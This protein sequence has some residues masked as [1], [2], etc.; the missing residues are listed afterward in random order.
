MNDKRTTILIAAMTLFSENG[1]H[2]TSMQEVADK[3]NVSK[4]TIY[5]YFSSK[6]D[7]LLS[8]FNYFHD[9]IKTHISESN[10]IELPPKEKFI[11]QIELFLQ[12]RKQYKGFFKMV[13]REQLITSRKDLHQLIINIQFET[14]KWFRSILLEIYGDKVIP[15]LPDGCLIVEA[16]MSNYLRISLFDESLVN[17]DH[18]ATFIVRRID[19]ILTAM[20]NDEEKPLLPTNL[21]DIIEARYVGKVPQEMDAE[22]VLKKIGELVKTIEITSDKRQEL[23]NSLS[24]IVDEIRKD[25]P[26]NFLI[27]GVLSNFDGIKEIDPYRQKLLQLLK[28]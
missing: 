20:I 12:E 21:F 27:K 13:H 11:K 4:G 2:A 25:A 10:H 7:L 18:M 1:V 24:F 8:I 28:I 26:Q 22:T 19:T 16:L 3:S 9:S 14:F 15:Y 17:M 6:E 23:K 5:T